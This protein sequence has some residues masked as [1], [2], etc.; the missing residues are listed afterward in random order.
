ML[1]EMLFVEGNHFCPSCEKSGNCELQAL[2]YLLGMTGAD[3]ALSVATARTRRDASRHLHRPQSL[4][5]LLPLH[6][7]LADCRRQIRLR[8]RRARHYM[9]G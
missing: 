2:G 6:P 7:R 1:I 3:A 9:S 5:S 8:F 4:H